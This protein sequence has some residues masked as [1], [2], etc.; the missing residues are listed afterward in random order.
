MKGDD[1]VKR[2]DDVKLEL[3]DTL[4][5]CRMEEPNVKDG[6]I[7]T[8][9]LGIDLTKD[10]EY[11][12][13][14]AIYFKIIGYGID[15]FEGGID[16]FFMMPA[17]IGIEGELLD[18]VHSLIY[19]FEHFAEEIQYIIDKTLEILYAHYEEGKPIKSLPKE[20]FK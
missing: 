5:E 18:E 3:S 10:D 15:G 17:L 7:T 9:S 12:G 19:I 8:Y 13:T 20:L 1:I 2:F 14:L 4:E 16:T 11:L 6:Y